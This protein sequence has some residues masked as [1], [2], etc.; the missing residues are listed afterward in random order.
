MVQDVPFVGQPGPPPTEPM[1][2]QKLSPAST[3]ATQADQ[4]RVSPAPSASSSQDAAFRRLQLL[5]PSLRSDATGIPKPSNVL[6]YWPSE[7]GLDTS[8]YISSVAVASDRQ[9]DEARQ[10]LQRIEARR[11]AHAEKYRRPAFMRQGFPSD[12]AAD[13]GQD[14]RSGSGSG[15]SQQLPVLQPQVQVRTAMPAPTQIMSSQQPPTSSQTGPPIAMSQPAPGAFGDRK[16]A[17]KAKKKS[18]FR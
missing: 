17:K 18:G 7:R 12:P 6:S 8:D 11:K 3:M 10:R 9:F 14:P 1:E 16:K 4:Q 15:S 13:P 5:A 2:K